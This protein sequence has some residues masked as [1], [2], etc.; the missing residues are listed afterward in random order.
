MIVNLLG[1]EYVQ[2]RVRYGAERVVPGGLSVSRAIGDFS[3]KLEEFGGKEGCLI[4]EPEVKRV[5]LK[6][7]ED[8]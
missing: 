3:A 6:G 2:E 8:F 7:E 1:V 5:L 4:A